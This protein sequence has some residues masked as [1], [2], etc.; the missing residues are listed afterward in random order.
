M[1]TEKRRKRKQKDGEGEGGREDSPLITTFTN[2]TLLRVSAT[3]QWYRQQ[4][5]NFSTPVKRFNSGEHL[6]SKSVA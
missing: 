2:L 6:R 4:Q 5:I 1:A 3:S